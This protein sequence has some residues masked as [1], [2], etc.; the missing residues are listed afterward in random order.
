MLNIRRNVFE[1]N[2]SSSHSISICSDSNST[3]KLY[4]DDDG[5]VKLPGGEFGWE[6]EE[7]YYAAAKADYCAVWA[8]QYGSEE[9]QEMLKKVI[10]EHTGAKEVVFDFQID[11]C[12]K[13]N[14]SYIDHQSSDVAVD[15][16]ASE[17]D[18][19]N[20]IFNTGSVLITDNDNH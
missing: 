4:V 9:D 20:F 17:E 1:T 19:K 12:G 8:V 16:F 13:D 14:W 5:I 15:V 10:C 2:S 18:L 3:D 6:Y 7:Y 11:E